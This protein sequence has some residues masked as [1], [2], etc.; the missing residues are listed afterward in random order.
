MIDFESVSCPKCGTVVMDGVAFHGLVR[1]ICPGCKRRVWV[2][3]DG[4]TMT[5]T[6]VDKK[7]GRLPRAP[8]A[9]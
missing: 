9:V 5:V 2:Q 3:G 7:P 4:K 6:R 1:P 8:A